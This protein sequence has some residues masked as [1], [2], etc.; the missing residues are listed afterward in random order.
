M[1]D[2]LQLKNVSLIYQSTEDEITAV[3]NL[4][5]SCPEGKFVSI[6][7]PSGCGKTTILSMIAGLLK[8]PQHLH[9]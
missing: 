9:S 4:S 8:P 3:D 5:F 7:G 1:K 2:I 6:I